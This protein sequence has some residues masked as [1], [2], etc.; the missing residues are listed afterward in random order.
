M[1]D[2]ACE[3]ARAETIGANFLKYDFNNFCKLMD[4][5]T[6]TSFVVTIQ[7]FDPLL[8]FCCSL[9]ERNK[10]KFADWLL[11]HSTGLCLAYLQ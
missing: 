9:T 8:D 7:N 3:F 4:Q 10:V 1:H 2:V 5:K 6:S 11:D